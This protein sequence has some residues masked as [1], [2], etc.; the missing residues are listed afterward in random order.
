MSSVVGFVNEKG[1]VGKTTISVHFAA[2]LSRA[3][4]LDIALVDCDAQSAGSAWIDASQIDV[5][6]Y[7]AA[8]DEVSDLITKASKAHDVVVVDGPAGLSDATRQ[9]ILL[10]DLLVIPVGGALLETTA[11]ARAVKIIREAQHAI[12]RVG[13]RPPRAFIAL[14]RIQPNTIIGREAREAIELLEMSILETE[15]RSLNAYVEASQN[16]ATVWDLPH[17]KS[18]ADAMSALCTEIGSRLKEQVAEGEVVDG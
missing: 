11:T 12:E 13:G 8:E 7:R 18:A 17:G 4:D 5:T 16:R 3:F 15:L 2:F 10:S 6:A 14:N 1:G 9:I